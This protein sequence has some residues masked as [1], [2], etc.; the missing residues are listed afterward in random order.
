M[1]F[2]Y[3]VVTTHVCI[4]GR[5]TAAGEYKIDMSHQEMERLV[6]EL[7][8]MYQATPAEW[9]TVE[10]IANYLMH[11]LGY[12]DMGE[13]EDALNGSLE[14]FL[15][16]LPNI[17]LS[18]DDKG[19]RVFKVKPELPREQWK[20]LKMTFP[21]KDRKDLWNVCFKSP[22]ARIEIPELEFEFS[23]D[24]K[25]HID[26][27]YNHMAAA[28]FNLGMHVRGAGLSEDHKNKIMDTI[29]V[30][31]VL[32]DV[33]KPFTWVVY[34]PTGQSDFSKME[35]VLVEEYAPDMA[36]QDATTARANAEAYAQSRGEESGI[37][38]VA[39]QEQAS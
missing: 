22:Y 6:S 31:N 29:I 9:I 2:S 35:G 4:M 38:E 21:I 7:E 26:S 24:G 1:Y 17:E 20:A 13:F 27:I 18:E 10:A 23:A 37:Q 19:R 25:R 32:L 15:S 36:E 39:A 11:D 8:A 12:E 28:I 34:D 3:S 30:L 16:A 5:P 14:Q 33:E